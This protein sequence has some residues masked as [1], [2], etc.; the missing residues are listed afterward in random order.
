MPSLLASPAAEVAPLRCVIIDDDPAAIQIIARCVARTPTLQLDGTFTDGHEALAFLRNQLVEVLF[1]DV[2]MPLLSGL[3]LLQLLLFQLPAQPYTV[4]IT[5]SPRH[6]VQAFD[7]AVVDYLLKPV[8]F[9]RFTQ[10]VRKVEALA[11]TP[12]ATQA[13]LANELD[14]ETQ[15]FM[16][17]KNG[18]QLVRVDYADIGYLEASHGYVTIATNQ[19][20]LSIP[21]TLQALRQ[22][23][24]VA[25]FLL[26]HRSFVVNVSHIESVMEKELVVLGRRLPVSMALRKQL[27]AQLNLL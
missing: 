17:V 11:T 24:P 27:L 12:K 26:V 16:F 3:D 2:E 22:R 13:L 5:S 4:L 10:A 20:K 25:G 23:L 18:A 21:G 15:T 8:T 7:Y 6:A 9:A 1:L 14:S 19:Q